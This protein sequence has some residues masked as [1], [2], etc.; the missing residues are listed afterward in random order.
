MREDGTSADDVR[1]LAV[2]RL[3]SERSLRP[4]VRLPVFRG[5]LLLFLLR[6]TTNALRVPVAHHMGKPPGETRPVLQ[7]CAQEPREAAYRVSST[8]P[9][10]SPAPPPS[11]RYSHNLA[12]LQSRLTVAGET[13]STSAASST[14][15]PPKNRI[16][17]I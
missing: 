12:I 4:P 3:F 10:P 9:N 13:F 7:A 14:L 1:F 17:M 11:S 6:P 16:S 2:V 8:G 15:S 5:T